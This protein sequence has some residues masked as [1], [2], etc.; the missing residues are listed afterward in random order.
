MSAYLTNVPAGC[1]KPISLLEPDKKGDLI[2]GLCVGIPVFESVASEKIEDLEKIE[3]FDGDLAEEIKASFSLILNTNVSEKNNFFTEKDKNKL[4]KVYEEYEALKLK[5]TKTFRKVVSIHQQ[6]STRSS[7]SKK[8]N[9]S[10]KILD[11]WL[12][13]SNKLSYTIIDLSFKSNFRHERL[14]RTIEDL[15]SLR[16]L[17]MRYK[18]F[19][20]RQQTLLAGLIAIDIPISFEELQIINNYRQLNEELYRGIKEKLN[21]SDISSKIN[22]N[23]LNISFLE[24]INNKENYF[25][26]NLL[27]M[28]KLISEASSWD[29]F[30]YNL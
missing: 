25:N 24:L 13:V 10:E 19:N 26:K 22:K 7:R 9:N 15:Q 4:L 18:E 6:H 8:E 12:P 20:S 27:L 17:L 11:S 21:R 23:N 1:G 30:S 3:G 2:K 29:K 5:T 14:V 28:Q 16:H